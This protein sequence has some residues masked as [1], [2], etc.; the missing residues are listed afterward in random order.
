MEGGRVYY[1]MVKVQEHIKFVPII[2]DFRLSTKDARVVLPKEIS[3][4]DGIYNVSRAS[5]M[6]TALT[7]GNHDLLKYACR[8]VFHENYRSKLINGFYEDK[9]GIKW[10]RCFSNIFKWGGS[11]NNG[12]DF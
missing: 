7:N 10:I 8:D 2:P 6:V 3:L 12:N 5:L 11:N 9:R 4:K 1:D